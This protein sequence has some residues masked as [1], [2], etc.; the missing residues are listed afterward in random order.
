VF[1]TCIDI[2][3]NQFCYIVEVCN[4]VFILLTWP[5]LSLRHS[6]LIKIRRFNQYLV[7]RRK[8]ENAMAFIVIQCIVHD[9][10]IQYF[11][12]SIQVI[13]IIDIQCDNLN[14]FH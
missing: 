10:T 7:N 9:I 1:E 3:R 6:C 12:Q 8:G 2:E 5:I 13:N 11:F 4:L 14:S